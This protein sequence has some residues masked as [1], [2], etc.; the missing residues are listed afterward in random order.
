MFSSY[1]VTSTDSISKSWYSNSDSGLY[2]IAY[3]GAG[4]S[5][6]VLPKLNQ[7]NFFSIV[8]SNHKMLMPDISNLFNSNP[9]DSIQ[10]YDTPRKV[11]DYPLKKG[12]QSRHPPEDGQTGKELTGL[13]RAIDPDGCLTGQRTMLFADATANT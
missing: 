9:S 5:Q 11:L 7:T 3:T 10:L 4:R 1:E 12:A 8:F 13:L 6:P 2:F